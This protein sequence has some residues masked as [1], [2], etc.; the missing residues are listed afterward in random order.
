MKN[1]L[2]VLLI[3]P[4]LLS[5]SKDDSPDVPEGIDLRQEMRGLVIN[6]ATYSRSFDHD[7]MVIP[8]N[9]IELVSANGEADGPL[10]TAYA[11]TINGH[12]QEDLFYGYDHDD[13]PT[14]DKE[15]QYL[16]SFL[17]KSKNAGNVILV[18][19]YCFSHDNMDDSYTKNQANSYISFAADHRE[20]DHIPDHPQPIYGENER[21][22]SDLTDISNFLYLINPVSFNSREEFIHAVTSTNYDLII[23]DLFFHDNTPFTASE[24]EQLRHKANGGKR[25]VIC[26]MSIGE[27]EDYRYYWQQDWNS[28]K[29]SWLDAENPDWEGNY[30]VKYWEKE[31]QDIIFGNDSSYL[32]KI[33]DADFD[34]VYLD[35]IDA[36]EY[37]E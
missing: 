6:I 14:P 35:I 30:K 37:Y 26:Y 9:G 16:R 4:A 29:P 2:F 24:I 11:E 33:I 23:M 13:R 20:L 18:T 7:F 8:Q 25:L 19:D 36:Y 3:L 21:N 17:E 28:D 27:A 31:W 12:G 34:G 1:F 15:N 10:S 5:C 22:I 32:K